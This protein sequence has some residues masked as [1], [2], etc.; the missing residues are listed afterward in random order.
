MGSFNAP[1]VSGIIDVWSSN[2][3]K[4]GLHGP[5]LD[6]FRLV[7]SPKGETRMRFAVKLVAVLL[8]AT[9]AQVTEVLSGS[10]GLNPG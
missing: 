6:Y 3:V 7:L 4:G 10:I 8:L 1:R 5:V 2:E 9:I